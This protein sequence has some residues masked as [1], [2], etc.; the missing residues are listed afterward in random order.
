MDIF[1]FSK[2]SGGQTYIKK[3]ATYKLTPDGE[4]KVKTYSGEEKEYSVMSALVQLG[5]APATIEEID[6][7]AH[8]GQSKVKRV[9]DLL[10]STNRVVKAGDRIE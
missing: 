7:L 3:Q 5:P 10:M 4:S 6:E 1:N 2:G 9:L 8:M